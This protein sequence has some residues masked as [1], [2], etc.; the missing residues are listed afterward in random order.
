MRALAI[1]LWITGGLMLGSSVA[2]HHKRNCT[3]IGLQSLGMAVFWPAL[4]PVAAAAIM[5]GAEP[6]VRNECAKK[7]PV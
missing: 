3:P 7:E 4:V 6:K 1:Y 2:D 5:L